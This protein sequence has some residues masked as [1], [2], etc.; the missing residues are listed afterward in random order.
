MGTSHTHKGATYRSHGA[1]GRPL[2]TTPKLSRHAS[3]GSAGRI[4]RASTKDFRVQAT[5]CRA[6]TVKT[7]SRTVRECRATDSDYAT[8]SRSGSSDH[9]T[10]HPHFGGLWNKD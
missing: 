2:S 1:A 4:V 7:K 10:R 5:Q 8:S 3:A 9:L 6:P